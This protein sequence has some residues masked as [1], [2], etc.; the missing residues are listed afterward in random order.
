MANTIYQPTFL[1]PELTS[2][3]MVSNQD[4]TCIV[5]GTTIDSYRLIIYNN[6]TSAVLYDT[7]KTAL[8]SPLYN[9]DTLAITVT[10]GTV[11][12]GLELKYTI[13]YWNGAESVISYETLFTSSTTATLSIAVPNPVLAQAQEFVGTYTQAEGVALQ[14]WYY[15]L[16]DSDTVEL[17]R[18]DVSFSGDVRHTFSGFLNGSSLKIQGFLKTQAGEDIESPLYSFDVSYAVP[19][20]D[21]IPSATVQD[22]TTSVLAA[23]GGISQ[24][25][26][27]V[28]GGSSAYI[29]NFLYTGNWGLELGVGAILS[30]DLDIPL[31]KTFHHVWVQESASF[32]GEILKLSNTGNTDYHEVGYD[33]DKFYAEINGVRKY[34]TQSYRTDRVYII[35]IRG[36]VTLIREYYYNSTYGYISDNYTHSEM[37]VFTHDELETI[38]S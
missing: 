20:L 37:I 12:N 25:S 7:T 27:T 32:T 1:Q 5:D 22:S 10:G 2:V 16:Y 29:E 6:D 30:Y 28:T 3:D 21:I 9:G 35:V 14:E 34:G 19:V 23:W 24:V 18:S 36:T 26:G 17:S 15:V 8:G 4:F 38:G 11:A 13:E 31:T 33:N